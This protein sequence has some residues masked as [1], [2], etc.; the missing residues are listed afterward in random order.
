M[1]FRRTSSSPSVFA[2][3][4][5]RRYWR[6]RAR[7]MLDPNGE[8]RDFLREEAGY[9]VRTPTTVARHRKS[10]YDL[11]RSGNDAVPSPT[12]KG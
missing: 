1:S 6:E 5:Y 11:R 12:E 4:Q 7:N 3:A 2:Q 8:V 10:D 9:P